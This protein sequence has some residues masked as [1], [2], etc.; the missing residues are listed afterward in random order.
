M[1]TAV[2]SKCGISKPLSEFGK[3]KEGSLGRRTECKTCK[4]EYNKK[5]YKKG[6][7]DHLKRMRNSELKRKYGITLAQ[8][9]VLNEV[10]N[11]LCAICGKSNKSGVG[12]HVDHNHVTGKLRGLLCFKCNAALGMVNDNIELLQNMIQYLRKHNG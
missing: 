1:E 12:L 3:R 7:K 11:G 5:W 4:R 2:C 10:Q 9:E 8:Y 6:K